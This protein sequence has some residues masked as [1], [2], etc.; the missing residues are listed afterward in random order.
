MKK[1]WQDRQPKAI[2]L[3]NHIAT[4]AKHRGWTSGGSKRRM[5]SWWN[6]AERPL[7][8]HQRVPTSRRCTG[9]NTRP[10]G[11]WGQ[12]WPKQL[13]L[14]R[15]ELCLWPISA[16]ALR[17]DLHQRC[18]SKHDEVPHVASTTHGALPRGR[19]RRSKTHSPMAEL[20]MHH[21]KHRGQPYWRGAV[22]KQ[23]LGN[24]NSEKNGKTVWHTKNILSAARLRERSPTSQAK[25]EGLKQSRIHSA[26]SQ[27]KQ[28]MPPT[29]MIQGNYIFLM[30]K[31]QRQN[32]LMLA[33]NINEN[34]WSGHK[35]A[36]EEQN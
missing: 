27:S 8:L 23:S 25:E 36:P 7:P 26:I 16:H 1:R 18:W 29:S 15:Q 12:Q 17:L 35:C 21:A 3:E 19:M 11:Q 9:R 30:C 13:A 5:R 24:A 10:A 31:S 14:P 6:R 4:V 32:T 33:K 22:A 20:T 2:L 34:C 28:H